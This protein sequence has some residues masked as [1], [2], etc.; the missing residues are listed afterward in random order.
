ML[1]SSIKKDEIKRDWFIVDAKDKTLGRLAS[2]I[3]QIIRGKKKPFYTPNMDM[4]DFVVVIN[5][6]KVFL[7]GDKEKQKK[8]FKHSGYPGGDK[9][10]SL[11]KL[12][13]SKPEQIIFNAVK[14][15]LPHNRLGRKLL[16]HLKV[17]S[18][19][20]HPHASQQPKPYNI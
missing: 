9:E 1:T 5:A 14:G 4:G 6:D 16:K 3:A 19:S 13:E 7:T 20:E 11:S 2:E 12:R 15:M 10:I 18:G 17:Y 8:Y